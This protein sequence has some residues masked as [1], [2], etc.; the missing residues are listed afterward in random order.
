MNM[1]VT[2]VSLKNKLNFQVLRCWV[3]VGV[4]L[5][6]VWIVQGG[7]H[8]GVQGVFRR[9]EGHCLVRTVDDRLDWMIL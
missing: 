1:Q 5:P 3:A 6:Y 4:W 8:K 2:D 9:V 7:V